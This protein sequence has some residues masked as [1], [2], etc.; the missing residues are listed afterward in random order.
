MGCLTL[1]RRRTL[2]R[3]LQYNDVD[4]L[5]YLTDVLTRIVNGHPNRDIDQLLSQAYRTEAFKAVAWRMTL[6]QSGH[7][8][9]LFNIKTSRPRLDAVKPVDMSA[10]NR[11]AKLAATYVRARDAYAEHEIA[12]PT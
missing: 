9:T 6:T 8:P 5:A 2:G 10:S 4:P 1:G 12:K 7:P 11:W 3:D